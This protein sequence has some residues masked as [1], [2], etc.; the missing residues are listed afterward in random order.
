[1][2]LDKAGWD[3][4]LL[5]SGREFYAN[6]GVIGLDP[7]S[8]NISEGWDG[9]IELDGSPTYDPK[10][11]PPRSAPWTRA[12]KR[13]LADFMIDAWKRFKKHAA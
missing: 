6:C 8:L 1:M 12:E 5:S 4:Y 10:T 11:D 13:E 7:T 2:K 9:G 3:L